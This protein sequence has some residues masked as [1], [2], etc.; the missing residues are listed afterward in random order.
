MRSAAKLLGRLVAL[1]ASTL[2]LS[3]HGCSVVVDPQSK[4]CSNDGDCLALGSGFEGTFCN[5]QSVCQQRLEFCST[6]QQ[7][8]ERTQSST[9]ICRQSDNRC[10]DLL[11]RECPRLLADPGDLLNNPL[12]LGHLGFPSTAI[13][14]LAGENALE[15]ARQE[16]RDISGG[17]PGASPKRPVVVISCDSSVMNQE[18]HKK[19][20]DHVIDEVGVPIIFGPIPSSWAQYTLPKAIERDTLL[21]TAGA[22]TLNEGG[23]DR[24]GILFRNNFSN[25]TETEANAAFIEKVIEPKI[26][27]ERGLLPEQQLRLAMVYS[28]EGSSASNGARFFQTVRFNGKSGPENAGNYQQFNMGSNTA[29]DSAARLAAAAIDVA[30]FKPDIVAIYDG[31]NTDDMV[32]AVEERFPGVA[33]FI[34]GIPGAEQTLVDAFGG[35][36]TKRKRI[37]ISQAG[38]PLTDPNYGAFVLQYVAEFPNTATGQLAGVIGAPQYDQFY[39]AMYAIAAN[40]SG[41][42]PLSGRALGEVLTKRMNSGTEIGMGPTKINEATQRLQRGES[43]VYRGAMTSSKFDANGDIGPPILSVC[44]SKDASLPNRYVESGIL[45]DGETKQLVGTDNCR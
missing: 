10:I 37:W 14:L 22:D 45:Y 18:D 27:A 41:P 12:I 33:Y 7:C 34:T 30:A 38:R 16:F 40:A 31:T 32:L 13:P 5:E 15:M 9:Y 25:L 2:V 8:Q 26:R 20:A 21:L 42:A 39:M 6:N 28:D 4:Q 23:A 35:D 11:T 19:A 1:S 43:I 29:P 17:V 24:L 3:T 44:V 36:E